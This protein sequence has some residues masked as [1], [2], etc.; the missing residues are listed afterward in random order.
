MEEKVGKIELR[1]LLRNAFTVIA[2]IFLV[3]SAWGLYSSL[4]EL[5]RIWIDYKYAPVYRALL[6]LSVVIL[7]IYIINLLV[8]K[9]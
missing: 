1:D 2:V 4:N 9:R 5:I 6:N 7:A 3:I 8:R